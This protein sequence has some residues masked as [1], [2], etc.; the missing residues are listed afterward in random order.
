MNEI[1]PSQQLS[2]TQCGGEL[3]PDQGQIF[4]TCP[5]CSAAVYLDK[6]KVV[7]HWYLAP[8]LDEPK[9]RAALARWMAGSQTV[10]DLDR[11]AQLHGASFAYFPVWHFIRIDSA[12]REETVLEPAAA[13]SITEL[14][15]INLP[16]GD[17][18]KYI[19]DLDS[20]AVAPTVPLD[21]AAEW[22]KGRQPLLS[23]ST[24]N[25]M[26]EAALVHLP[27]YQFKYTYGGNQYTALVEAGTGK[28][29]ANIFPAKAEA[30][31]ILAGVLTALVYLCLALFPIAGGLIADTEGIIGGAIL[32]S[33]IGLAAAPVLFALAAWV[34]AKV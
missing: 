11:K 15:Q 30:P 13:T 3:H 25:R 12:G 27:L 26:G 33:G 28:V 24:T 23:P 31:F 7:F 21:A 19:P 16:A 17:L 10:K 1:L 9:A 5:Y 20:Q 6:S 32:C 14:R 22:V 34:A 18:R 2:C 29:F 4:L 8:T